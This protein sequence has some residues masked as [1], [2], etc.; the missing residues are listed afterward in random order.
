MRW[1]D[2]GYTL[3]KLPSGRVLL[4]ANDVQMKRENGKNVYFYTR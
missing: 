1:R 3:K 4:V 2:V